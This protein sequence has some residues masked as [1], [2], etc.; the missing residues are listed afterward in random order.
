VVDHLFSG[1][2]LCAVNAAG[3]IVLPAFVR[4]TL[5]RRGDAR[6]LLIG[7][8]EYDPCLIAYDTAF[9]RALHADCERRRIAEEREAPAASARRLRRIFGLAET[10]TYGERGAI[11]LPQKIRRHARI[12][13]LVLV[14]GIGAAFEIWSLE[15]ALDHDDPGLRELAAFHGEVR[16]VA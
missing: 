7:S 10:A 5:S 14:V 16:H 9:A 4:A 15:A 12:E 11:V 13:A 1:S 2:A 3:G 8:H 6:I